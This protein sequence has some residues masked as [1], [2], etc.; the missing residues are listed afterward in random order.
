[1]CTCGVKLRFPYKVNAPP[2]GHAAG[3]GFH[4][5]GGGGGLEFL[6]PPQKYLKLSMVIIVL[7]LVLN[8]NLVPDFVR[9]NLR[10]SKFNIF[11]E[12]G[13]ACPQT[14]LV[15]TH[16]YM[17]VSMLSHAYTCVSMLSHTTIILL[18]SCFSPPTQNPA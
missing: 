4:T 14:P 12:G 9:S 10:G 8:N 18:P 15:G 7:S 11:L 17:C 13:G 16:A 3:A 2:K 1:M 5:D 6:P